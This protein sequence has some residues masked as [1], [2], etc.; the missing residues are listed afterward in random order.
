MPEAIADEDSL[1]LLQK[2]K[3]VVGMYLSAHPLDRY[4]FEIDS[5]T[6]CRLADLPQE[7]S[8]ATETQT[9]R[10]VYLAGIVT[11]SKMTTTRSGSPSVRAVLEDYSGTYEIALF[12]KDV[13]NFKSFMEEK[14]ELFVE[15]E[16]KA[17]Y[18]GKG[19]N[20][21]AKPDF[22]FRISKV[23]SLGNVNTAYLGGFTIPVP[24]PLLNKEFRTEFVKLLK[25]HKGHTPLT[26]RLLDPKYGA[27]DTAPRKLGVSVDGTFTDE[28]KKMGLSYSI[29]SSLGR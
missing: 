27:I 21:P 15:G 18:F 6:N 19:E 22:N 23:I 4:R 2:E 28:L 10:K 9:G 11:S 8:K 12:G 16:L 3:E 13:D 20:A 17:R 24:T 7:I 26:I 5:F 29:T 25:H 1:L 14:R